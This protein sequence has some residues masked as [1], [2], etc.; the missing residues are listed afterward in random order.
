MLYE[1]LHEV[2]HER[3]HELCNNHYDNE[4]KIK[5]LQLYRYI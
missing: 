2:L 1:I 5:D 3:I 4:I